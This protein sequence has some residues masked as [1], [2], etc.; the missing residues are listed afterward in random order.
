MIA[1]IAFQHVAPGKGIARG[2]GFEV[3]GVSCY[4][5]HGL[6]IPVTNNIKPKRHKT[7]KVISEGL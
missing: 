1:Q 5:G 3:P 7:N 6:V 4:S 2:V